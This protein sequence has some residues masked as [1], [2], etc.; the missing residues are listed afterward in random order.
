MKHIVKSSLLV[1]FVCLIA[2]TAKAQ[3][4]YNY[5]QYDIG[6][7]ASIN[8]VYGDAQTTV[9]SPAA[10]FTFGYN[11][12]PF[13]NYIVEAQYGVLK[14]GDALTTS[15]G[16]QFD[17]KF[18]AV[19]FRGQL[20]AGEI[21]DYSQS[22][23]ANGLKNLYVSTGIGFVVNHLENTSRYSPTDA[24][25]YTGGK[26]NSNQLLIPARIGYE[27]KLYNKYDIPTFKI[28]IGYQ[29]NFILG[30]D[31]DGFEIGNQKDQYSQINIGIKFGFG[32]IN[33]YKKQISY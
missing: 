16:R 17:N 29:Y 23:L 1:L 2:G 14:G 32:G 15:T 21:M 27:F 12:G 19:I 24:T 33:S 22:K 3:L 13:I 9:N 7:G 18:T 28:D 31:L 30:D 10:H 11:V 26:D 25:F 6:L 20:Q 4:G 5:A 8:K